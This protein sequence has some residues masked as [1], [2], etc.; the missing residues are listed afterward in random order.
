MKGPLNHIV[1]HDLDGELLVLYQLKQAL[2]LR[3][4][5]IAPKL[6]AIDP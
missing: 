5:N 6:V 3:T 1:Y 2:P 4:K